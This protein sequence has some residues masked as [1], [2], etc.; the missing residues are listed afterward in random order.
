MKYILSILFIGL[1]ISQAQYSLV[2][3]PGKGSS[4]TLQVNSSFNLNTEM[5]G[6]KQV[7]HSMMTGLARFSVKDVTDSGVVM[8]VSF[9]SLHITSR[10]PMGKFEFTADR[11]DGE[12]AAMNAMAN[13]QFTITLAKNG[14]VKKIHHP[15]TAGMSA[16]IRNFPGFD[17]IRRMLMMGNMRKGF[18]QRKMK[19]DLEK[20]TSIFP[21][22]K[23]N[24]NEEWGYTI[25]P[26]S[27]NNRE[28]KTVY[29]L[30]SYQGGL[31]TIRGTSIAKA[32]SS[33][34]QDGR[35][36]A[37]YQ[38]DGNAEMSFTVDASTGWIQDAVIKRT[39]TGHIEMKD[40]SNATKSI[41]VQLTIEAKLTGQ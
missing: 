16:M 11:S 29:R 39:L 15:D 9:D 4:H 27:A 31:A 25:K 30:V 28:I 12:I 13:H 14:S 23:V 19:E 34:K 37:T 10:T 5:N 26:D 17:Q 22:K 8:E 2:F 35:M 1:Q 38:L 3:N 21:D 20:L 36:P 18:N 7:F 41:P 6:Q 33:D 32:T 24:I 40:R